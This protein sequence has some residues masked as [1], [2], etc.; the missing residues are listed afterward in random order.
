M[1]ALKV[2]A[3]IA[4]AILLIFAVLFV[5]AAFSPDNPNSAG[6]SIIV[7]LVLGLIGFGLIFWAARKPAAGPGDANVT[8]QVN[9]PGN[10]SMD[11]LKCKSCGGALGPDDVKWSPA[12]RWS[13][14]RT[15]KPP[16]S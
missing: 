15:A 13:P 12:R 2:I 14:V 6:G 11:T 7:G 9:L 1:S 16:T 10:V 8:L 5:L 3:Y 4:A